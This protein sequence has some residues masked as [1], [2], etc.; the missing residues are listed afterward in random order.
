M[1]LDWSGKS[2]KGHF[3]FLGRFPLNM[4]DSSGV[5]IVELIAH[6]LLHHLKLLFAGA[7]AGVAGAAD[8]F[9]GFCRGE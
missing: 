6:D 5:K 9:Q 1:T 8:V 4:Q 2:V 7:V 3:L